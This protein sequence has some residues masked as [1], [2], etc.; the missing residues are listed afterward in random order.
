[1]ATVTYGCFSQALAKRQKLLSSYRGF[2]RLSPVHLSSEHL[3]M[4][5][6]FEKGL[7]FTVNGLLSVY[8][9]LFS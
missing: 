9:S 5:L 1:M 3:L 8:V 4:K 2:I 6:G 7:L